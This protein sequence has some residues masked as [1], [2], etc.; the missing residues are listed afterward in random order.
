MKNE[1]ISNR[2][3]GY[4]KILMAACDSGS[5]FPNDVKGSEREA[6]ITQFLRDLLPLNLRISGGAITDSRGNLYNES[7]ISGQ[8]DIVIEQPNGL[9]IPL[10]NGSERLFLAESVIAVIEV[11]SDIE[12]QWEQ[13]LS[14]IKKIREIKRIYG[15][16]E[17]K[18]TDS[19]EPIPFYA[20]GYHGWKNWETIDNK[21]KETPLKYKPNGILVIDSGFFIPS[22]IGQQSR[23]G[24]GAGALYAFIS[25]VMDDLEGMYAKFPNIN[26]YFH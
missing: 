21:L 12:K 23:L 24:T 8:C 5:G 4:Q 7:N 26:R 16:G 15:A 19:E 17:A 18:S 14:S 22:G 25:S 1:Y 20:V 2:M 13:V 10:P 11:K 3:K 6:F 9:S